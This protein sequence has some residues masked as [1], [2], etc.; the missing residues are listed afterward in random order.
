MHGKKTCRSNTCTARIAALAL[1]ALAAL[2]GRIAV[3]AAQLSGLAAGPP[4]FL[5][6]RLPTRGAGLDVARLAQ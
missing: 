1:V 4:L 5:D 2:A 6:Q 3:C